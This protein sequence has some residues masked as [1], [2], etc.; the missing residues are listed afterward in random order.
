[1]KCQRYGHIALDYVNRKVITVV[2][3]EIKSIFGEER[4]DIHESFENETMGE[5]IYDE[6]YIGV[7]FHEMFKEEGNIDPIDLVSSYRPLSST[8]NKIDSHKPLTQYFRTFNN[9]MS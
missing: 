1:M 6:E 9:T 8:K 2:N 7:D 5:P 4:E 3:G